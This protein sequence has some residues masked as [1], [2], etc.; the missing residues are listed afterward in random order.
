MIFLDMFLAY[1]TAYDPA[2]R[3][4]ELVNWLKKF[5]LDFANLYFDEPDSTGHREGPDGTVKILIYFIYYFI[6]FIFM[7]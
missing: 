4:T 3:I 2:E 7:L 1:S 6:S 5:D